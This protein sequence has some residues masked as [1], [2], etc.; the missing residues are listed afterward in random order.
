M[1]VHSEMAKQPVRVL[2]L[3][4]TGHAGQAMVRRALERGREVTAVTRQANPRGLNDLPV[5]VVRIDPE[6]R[7]LSALAA[8]HD[9]LVDAAAPYNLDLSLPN[10]PRWD[11]QVNAAVRRTELVVEAARRHNLVL[12]YFSSY[13]TLP[14]HDEPPA[15]DRVLWRFLASP[16]FETKFA[17][18]Q[19][20]MRATNDRLRAI[21]VNPVAFV[22][23]WQLRQAWRF[24]ALE[25]PRL[26]P[27]IV[28][29]IMS[30]IDV[31]DVAEA[32][33]L[34]LEREWFGRPI[35][36]AG[37]NVLLTDL[38][39]R[40]SR[41]TGMLPPRLWPVPEF[42]GA[43]GPYMTHLGFTA[44]GLQPPPYLGLIAITPELRPV[45]PSPEQMELGLRLRSLEESLQD[46]AEFDRGLN[47][48]DPKGVQERGGR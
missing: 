31:R 45:D 39:A 30:V 24:V 17:M 3:G 33:D 38:L 4:A 22:G 11:S 12:V 34:A 43:F 5:R 1:L 42:A 46:A 13:G 15:A 10:S 14:R 37:H 19:A 26:A 29:R 48:S 21:I 35:P 25:L 28:N 2:V 40:T 16:Y 41:L 9:I 27:A 20:V 23:P 6:L 47:L 7:S 32:V 8:E 36:L 44:L 18:E